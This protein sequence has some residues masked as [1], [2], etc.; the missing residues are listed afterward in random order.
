MSDAPLHHGRAECSCVEVDEALVHD[1]GPVRNVGSESHAVGIG[2][3]HAAGDHVIDHA[4]EPVHAEHSDVH[5][6]RA[7]A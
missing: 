2:D 4:R 1:D 7:R 3:P 6:F 5:A